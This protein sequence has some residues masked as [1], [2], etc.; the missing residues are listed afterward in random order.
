MTKLGAWP[1][2]IYYLSWMT[3]RLANRAPEWTHG[4]KWS[5]SVMQ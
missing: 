4:R 1:Q 3:Q 2:D 5:W